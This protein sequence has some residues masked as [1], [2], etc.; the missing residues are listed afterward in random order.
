V[1]GLVFGFFYVL[2]PAALRL[3][4]ADQ[5]RLIPIPWIEL[6]QHTEGVLPAVATGLQ[7]D[8]GWCSSAWCCRSGP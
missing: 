1:I 7:L 8:L 4:L 6:T 5:I 3:L 2:L